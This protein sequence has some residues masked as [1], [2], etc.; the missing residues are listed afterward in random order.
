M[1]RINDLRQAVVTGNVQDA[2]KQT[3]D[4]LREGMTVPQLVDTAVVPAMESVVAQ[5]ARREVYM[6]ELLVSLRAACAAIRVAKENCGDG[7]T[8]KGIVAVGAVSPNSQRFCRQVIADLLEAFGY[9]V[10]D[11]GANSPASK[12]AVWCAAAG[13]SLLVLAELPLPPERPISQ[14]AI[15]EITK[16]ARE[17]QVR[18]IR[19]RTRIL[20]VGLGAEHAPDGAQRPDAACDDL[21]EIPQMVRQL[22]K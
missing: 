6:P 14:A 17:M 10:I 16:I 18:G 11:V 9:Q 8:P 5:F 4:F 15:A 13:A 20:W 7:Y 22:V 3:R 12:F 1:I 19:E 21:A 2:V